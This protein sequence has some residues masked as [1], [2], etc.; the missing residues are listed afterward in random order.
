[1]LKWSGMVVG[2]TAALILAVGPGAFTQQSPD[3][4]DGSRWDLFAYRKTRPIAG[5]D[6][7]VRFNDGRIWGEAGCNR[8]TGSYSV[9]GDSI[10]VR[11]VSAGDSVCDEPEGIM[12]Q[13]EYYL[14]F[15]AE[16]RLIILAGD[17]LRLRR[18]DGE[19]LTY[20]PRQCKK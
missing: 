1:M 2:A 5:H 19:E 9:H 12:E 3:P 13:E 7:T 4:L 11:G 6:L 8:Y 10:A 20:L 16:V 17:R 14:Q 18:T 15:L